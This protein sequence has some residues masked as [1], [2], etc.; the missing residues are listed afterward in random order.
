MK[1]SI[2]LLL[3]ICML[4]AASVHAG[5]GAR[6]EILAKGLKAVGKWLETHTLDCGWEDGAFMLGEHSVQ[7][8]YHIDTPSSITGQNSS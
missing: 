7:R 4:A 6:D 5:L 1:N 8:H 2:L 3:T